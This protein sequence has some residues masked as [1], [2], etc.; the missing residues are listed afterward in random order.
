MKEIE[1]LE[2][3]YRKVIEAY[4]NGNI[5]NKVYKDLIL[6]TISQIEYNRDKMTIIARENN[7]LKE[8]LLKNIGVEYND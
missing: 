5:S 4:N 7:S 8:T 3:Q 1:T 2:E 6:S